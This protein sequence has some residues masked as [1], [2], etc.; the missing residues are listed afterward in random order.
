MLYKMHQKD[1]V[2]RIDNAEG[3]MSQE[4]FQEYYLQLHV[5]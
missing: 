2:V 4:Y 5:F 1:I 3:K